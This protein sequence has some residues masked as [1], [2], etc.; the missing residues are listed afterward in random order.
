MPSL[1]SGKTLSKTLLRVLNRAL[2]GTNRW[3]QPHL[4]TKPR[5]QPTPMMGATTGLHRNNAAWVAF[6]IATE[7]SP[8]QLLAKYNRSISG[9]SVHMKN[10]LG[11]VD[12]N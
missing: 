5:N 8:R 1:T 3:N 7:L 4:M 12:P 11:K 6:H 9:S 10:A 2:L